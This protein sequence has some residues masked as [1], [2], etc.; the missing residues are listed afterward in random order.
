MADDNK[1]KLDNGVRIYKYG[2]LNPVFI[3]KAQETYDD[4]SGNIM[5]AM[6][7]TI[8]KAFTPNSM[9]GTGPYRGVVLRRNHNISSST[10]T[11]AI[12]WLA[13]IFASRGEESS[14]QIP[15]ELQSY[16][17]YIP[18][19]MTNLPP[20]TRYVSI[21]TPDPEHKKIDLYPT[22]ISADSNV[23]SAVEGDIV[24]VDFGNRVNMT[25]PV[26]LGP[27]F[28]KPYGDY[29][30]GQYIGAR[31][32]MN[33]P[34]SYGSKPNS[35]TGE[36]ILDRTGRFL[37]DA[38][39]A[40]NPF[41]GLFSDNDS[42]KPTSAAPAA[43]QDNEPYYFN[44]DGTSTSRPKMK[45]VRIPFD[46][47][48]YDHASGGGYPK[49]YM[50]EDVARDI[51]SIKDI[52]NNLGGVLGT[53]GGSRALTN[54]NPNNKNA[55]TTSF[56]Y[57]NMAFDIYSPGGSIDPRSNPKTC[58]YVVTR[59][60]EENSRGRYY[61]DI[62][63]RSDKPNARYKGY[64]VEKV[65]LKALNCNRPGTGRPAR[66]V[67][68]VGYY[69]NLWQIIKDHGFKRIS[70]RAGFYTN[71]GGGAASEWWHMQSHRGLVEGVSRWGDV[72]KKSNPDNKVEASPPWR[73]RNRVFRGKGFRRK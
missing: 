15:G 27:S 69:I 25:D 67:E 26:Y 54:Y 68:V 39:S 28:P 41:S 12:T 7:Q 11:P 24:L 23:P 50:R 57:T 55:S 8:R 33:A 56:H 10:T 64:R 36:D 71:C 58:E 17:V 1:P 43:C 40:L 35:T 47:M 46:K 37:S 20:V 16:Q 13:N 18:E 49:V 61:F 73:H 14:E 62:W 70:G 45:R 59:S 60:V 32:A 2:D 65:K 42:Q 21:H 51:M 29:A 48:R 31:D 52:V 5:T 38:A 22:F 63:A 9:E 72:L 66:E 4:P 30:D 34:C 44:N 3:N 19:L 6:R 53:Y